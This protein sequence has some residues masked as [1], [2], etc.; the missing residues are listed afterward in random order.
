VTSLRKSF[1]SS[2]QGKQTERLLKESPS[3]SLAR[4]HLLR[5]LERRNDKTISKIPA[6]E[7]STLF[8][9]LGSSGFLSDVLI[10]Q[11][12]IWPELFLRQ[13]RIEQKSRADHTKDLD[14]A[15]KNS[16]TFDE[17]CA[18]LRRHKQREYLRIGARDLMA[19]VTLDARSWESP[20]P[21]STLKGA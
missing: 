16:V 6:A 19:S 1:S 18:A 8:C 17:F 9:L 10:R 14:P 11:G 20:V 3:P 13:I 4:N 12:K 2:L 15:V 5:L 21:A 7:L